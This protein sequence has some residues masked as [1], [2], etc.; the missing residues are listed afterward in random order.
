MVISL[1]QPLASYRY[2]SAG[3]AWRGEFAFLSLVRSDS[4]PF[5]IIGV[6]VHACAIIHPIPLLHILLF[7]LTLKLSRRE[8]PGNYELKEGTKL[9]CWN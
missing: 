2:V 7:G 3:R 4:K 6:V 5:P 1:T 8:N 9:P